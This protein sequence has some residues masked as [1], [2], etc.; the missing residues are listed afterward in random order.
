MRNAKEGKKNEFLNAKQVFYCNMHVPN[1]SR[2]TKIVT[3]VEQSC[4]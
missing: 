3:K 2:L 1:Y 4:S